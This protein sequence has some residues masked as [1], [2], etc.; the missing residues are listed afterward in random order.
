MK[1]RLHFVDSMTGEEGHLNLSMT[2]FG[3]AALR[4]AI[5]DADEKE[6]GMR[7]ESKVLAFYLNG[8]QEAGV[9]VLFPECGSMGAY[10]LAGVAYVDAPRRPLPPCTNTRPSSREKSAAWPST[11][12]SSTARRRSALPP[13]FRERSCST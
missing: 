9:V 13:T 8:P 2:A 10:L 11:T 3:P 7:T 4:V 1:V 12:S 5:A 6:S